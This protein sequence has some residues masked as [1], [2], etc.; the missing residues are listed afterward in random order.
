MLAREAVE[1]MGPDGELALAHC[2]A[3]LSAAPKSSAIADALAKAHS[4]AFEYG[5]ALPKYP[6][7]R[8]IDEVNAPIAYADDHFPVSIA[9]RDLYSPRTIGFER[10][11]RRRLDYWDKVRSD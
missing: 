6:P 5:S 8:P 9:R 7:Q 4:L 2:V 3:I 10:E 1:F 11:L